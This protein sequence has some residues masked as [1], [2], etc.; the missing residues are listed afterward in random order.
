MVSYGYGVA[1][2]ILAIIFAWSGI[3]KLWQPT[4]AARAL[5]DFGVLRRV[6]PHLGSALGVAELLPASVSDRQILSFLI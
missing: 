2:W 6:R 3:A 4:L 5:V 1:I